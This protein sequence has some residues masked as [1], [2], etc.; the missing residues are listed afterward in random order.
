M[1]KA[2][3]LDAIAKS[4]SAGRAAYEQAQQALAGQQAEAVR[5][6]LASGVAGQAPSGAQAEIERIVSQ[7]YQSRTAQLAQNQASMEDWYNRL[8]ASRG[9]WADQQRA[10]QDVALQQALAEASGGGGG[11]GGGGGSDDNWY[12]QLRDVYGTGEIAQETIV[13]EALQNAG[14]NWRTANKSPTELR[15]EYLTNTYGVPPETAAVWIPESQ[16]ASRAQTEMNNARNRRE[17]IQALATIRR[18]A[19]TQ[20]EKNPGQGTGYAVN[21][22][23]QYVE[24]QYG[25]KAMKRGWRKGRK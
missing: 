1:D 25:T 13:N 6:A 23:R 5:M 8:S 2:A 19:R 18:K 11:G 9:S 17:A 14:S 24:R 12:D 20:N 4:G 7:P 10:L 16:F 21:Q 22:Q 3:L 15:R